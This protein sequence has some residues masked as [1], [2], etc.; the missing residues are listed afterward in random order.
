MKSVFF[1]CIFAI[2]IG[3]LNSLTCL[4]E[5]SRLQAQV[6]TLE[7]KV[8]QQQLK[9]MQL[10][11]QREALGALSDNG[12]VIELEGKRYADCAEI[13]N[14]GHHQSAF[15][16]IQPLMSS[17]S[18]WVYCDMTEGGGWTVIQRRVDGSVGFDRDWNDYK[19]GF[20]NFQSDNG[21]YWLGNDNIHYLTSQGDYNLRINLQDF[22][23][24]SRHAEY[25]NFKVGQ[26][27]DSYPLS[28]G[29]YSG[30]AG[31]S[32]SGGFHPEVQWWANHNGMKFSTRDRD[33][34][35]YEKNC[36]KE[37]RSG[38]WFNRCHAANLNGLYYNGPYSADT[39]NGIVWYTWRGWWY[40]LKSVVMKIRPASFQ[41]TTK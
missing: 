32:L 40:S 4:E 18:F 11:T 12:N 23:E 35:R 6:K 31:D 5:Q 20:G 30:S 15:Y 26:E 36:A 17:R 3:Q 41:S 8:K 34:D 21:E 1:L 29:S 7:L 19:Q 13:Y 24:G 38:W 25:T 9:I 28:F 37:D 22:E 14:A 16:N 27:Q 2:C 39:D 10:L 33:N